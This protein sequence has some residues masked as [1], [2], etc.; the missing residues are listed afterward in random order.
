MRYMVIKIK[1]YLIIKRALGLM[2][3]EMLY[4][5]TPWYLISNKYIIIKKGLVKMNIN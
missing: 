2:F 1:W 4:G 3:F 5:Y